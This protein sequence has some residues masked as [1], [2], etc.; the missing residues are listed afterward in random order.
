MEISKEL[1]KII[2]EDITLCEQVI[3]RSNKAEL[4]EIHTRIISKYSNIINGFSENLQSTFY[5]E[6]G[7]AE[8][9]NIETM[10]QKL[11]LFK[12]M[13]YSNIFEKENQAPQVNV[14]NINHNAIV[15]NMSFEQVRDNV[16]NMTALKEEEIKDILKKIG[17]IENIVKSTERKTKK[18]E[19]VKPII[20]WIA[21]KSIDIG[22]IMLQL[23]L[24]IGQ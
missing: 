19:K 2:D 23:L 4:Y 12:A 5:D 7:T 14:S 22:M 3:Q 9:R 1:I 11:V 6:T 13:G 18:W 17:E 10:R 24:K 15:N 16:E 21:D 20:I 8:K